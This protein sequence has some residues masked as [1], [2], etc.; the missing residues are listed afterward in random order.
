MEPSPARANNIARANR[1][2]LTHALGQN[3]RYSPDA[4]IVTLVTLTEVGEN[5]NTNMQAQG[6]SFRATNVF[7]KE[8]GAWK[9]IH[10][11]T[12]LLPFL[13]N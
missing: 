5:T 9:M 3:H 10:H 13:D 8:D 12:D 11:H 4:L 2:T 1:E 6:V 7:R